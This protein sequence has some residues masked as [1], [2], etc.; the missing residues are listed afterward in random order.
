M[1]RASAASY[2][3]CRLAHLPGP[4]GP[5]PNTRRTAVWICEYPYRTVRLEGPSGDCGDCPVW[6]EMERARQESAAADEI[7]QLEAMLP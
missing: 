2:P 3:Q 7:R 5:G 4:T 1:P 6:R